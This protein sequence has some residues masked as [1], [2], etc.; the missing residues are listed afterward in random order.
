MLLLSYHD[1][2]VLCSI[3]YSFKLD[4]LRCSRLIEVCECD[5]SMDTHYFEPHVLL[6]SDVSNKTSSYKKQ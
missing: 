6:F 1:T 5:I 3:I 2:C 4:S